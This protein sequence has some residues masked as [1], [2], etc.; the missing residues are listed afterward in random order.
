MS[1]VPQVLQ[2]RLEV[3][4]LTKQR[5][6]NVG[7]RF[8]E[9]TVSTVVHTVTLLLERADEWLVAVDARRQERRL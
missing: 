9:V 7:G 6:L 5:L 4:P 2:D 1:E 3:L 8:G